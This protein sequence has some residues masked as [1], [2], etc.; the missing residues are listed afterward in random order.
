MTLLF[1]HT[2]GAPEASAHGHNI[3]T[4]T[5]PPS[6]AGC[7]HRSPRSTS[8]HKWSASRRTHSHGS[9]RHC[10]ARQSQAVAASLTYW[11]STSTRTRN[12]VSTSDILQG[13]D[14]VVHI[15]SVG[16]AHGKPKSNGNSTACHKAHTTRSRGLKSRGKR[17]LP[18]LD[19]TA[20][21]D[22]PPPAFPMAWTLA[23]DTLMLMT[24]LGM[25]TDIA[26]PE[27]PGIQ[28]VP[29]E[30]MSPVAT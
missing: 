10:T 15:A 28:V 24:L 2:T 22:L 11:W 26:P 30:S 5:P 3:P 16:V 19:A 12:V 20:C 13:D 8:N 9:W 17:G 14:S 23:I 6:R 21:R 7:T 1:G 27:G 4:Y 29:S 25:T 18:L